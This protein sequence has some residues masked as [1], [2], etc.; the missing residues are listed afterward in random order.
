MWGFG[1][2]GYPLLAVLAISQFVGPVRSTRHDA[3]HVAATPAPSHRAET[4]IGDDHA[5]DVT[6]HGNPAIDGEGS[7]TLLLLL[8]DAADRWRL[9]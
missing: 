9:R 2:R 7:V 5:R 3:S 1:M 6:R 8:E 4:P